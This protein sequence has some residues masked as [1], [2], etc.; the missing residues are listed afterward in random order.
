ADATIDADDV[1]ILSQNGF[2]AGGQITYVNPA[3]GPANSFDLYVRGLLPTTTGLTLGQIATV[4]L[5]GNEKFFIYWFHNPL[6]QFVFNE[7][8]LLPGQHVSVGGPA[9]G[10]SNASAVMVKRVVLRDWGFNTTVVANS[11]NTSNGTFQVQI[12]GFAGQLVPQ[13]VTVYTA[14]G[15]GFR[16]GLNGVGDLTGGENVRV[17]GLLIKSPIDGSTVLAARYVDELK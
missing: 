5:S 15:T 17:V 7:S 10:A 8:L 4:D 16:D 2:Y 9:S 11:V 13:T 12:N 6:T 1:A 14:G 3:T